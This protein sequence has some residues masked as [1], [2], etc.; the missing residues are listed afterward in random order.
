MRKLKKY[1]AISIILLANLAICFNCY[2]TSDFQ[3]DNKIVLKIEQSNT[4]TDLKFG[5]LTSPTRLDPLDAYNIGSVNVIDQICERLYQY[6][7]SSPD[8]ELIPALAAGMPNINGT[9]ITIPL[10]SGIYFHDGTPFNA[11]AVKWNFDRL[12]HFI[13]YSGNAWLPA[14][15]N[16]P[17]T[18][19]TIL[20]SLYSFEDKPIINETIV[21][22]NTTV[23]IKLNVPKA[24]ILNLLTF[25]GSSILSPTSTPPLRLLQYGLSDILVGTG[26]FI[27]DYYLTG[28]EVKMLANSNYWMGPPNINTL[29]FEIYSN[30]ILLNE[31][32]LMG[33]VD[34]IDPHPDYFST[35]ELDPDITLLRGGGTF[36]TEYVCMNPVRVNKTWRQS[37][38]YAINYTYIIDVL[39]EERAVRLKSPIPE[40][41]QF[42]NYTLNYPTFNVTKARTIINNDLG[43]SYDVNDDVL[44]AGLNF[45]HFWMVVQDNNP[46]R[47]AYT[48]Y[49]CNVVGPR[50]GLDIE[51]YTTTFNKLVYEG[52]PL[53]HETPN[54]EIWPGI[55]M[56]LWAIG[57]APDY[58]DPE[59][60]LEP[61]LHNDSAQCVGYHNIYLE[62]L[63]DNASLELDPGKRKAYYDEIQQIL[64]E[65]DMPFAWLFTPKN[66]DA[67]KKEVGGYITNTGKRVYIYPCYWKEINITH[68]ADIIYAEGQTGHNISWNITSNFEDSRFYLL[69]VDGPLNKSDTWDSGI[70]VNIN[71][72]GLPVGL[73]EYRIEVFSGG[74]KWT[75]DIVYVGVLSLDSLPIYITHPLNITYTE[76]QTGNNIIWSITSN[77][78]VSPHYNLYVDDVFNKTDSWASGIPVV[79]NVDGHSA[80]TYEYRIEV[81]NGNT[82]DTDTV[83]VFVEPRY[84]TEPFIYGYPVLLLL[85]IC[86]SSIILISI[87]KK[88]NIRN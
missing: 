83:Y 76:G 13:N 6:N 69:F 17:A 32:L 33:D 21:V 20:R 10:K 47:Q 28:V 68:P 16:T 12:N 58:L 35:L 50:I 31:A 84:V 14:P 88:I 52:L 26:P 38:S 34:I 78:L 65:D 7:L 82:I 46:V 15:F 81:H 9:E 43:T 24:S 1:M 2:F 22:N 75:E 61:L 66:Y 67:Y 74:V 18:E 72:D 60:Y 87:R 23:K 85:L 39:M 8:Y 5:T 40:G 71:V 37:I 36:N 63:M 57:W 48:D 56:D 3:D 73:H 64:V 44:W 54:D 53:G 41:I 27:Y 62:E 55:T 70:P 11:T 29:F 51:R 45:T 80:G 77:V 19:L 4:P 25:S 42:S 49:V 59:N 86:L 79:I 30:H